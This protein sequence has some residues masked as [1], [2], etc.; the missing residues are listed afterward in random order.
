MQIII[1]PKIALASCPQTSVHKQCTHLMKYT[2]PS[3][4][5]GVAGQIGAQALHE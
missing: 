3:D 5:C 2:L 1:S 4:T